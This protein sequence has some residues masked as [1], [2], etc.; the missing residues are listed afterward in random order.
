MVN[1]IL[2]SLSER[3]RNKVL[4]RVLLIRSNSYLSVLELNSPKYTYIVDNVPGE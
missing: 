1:Y 4:N 3:T 2:Y